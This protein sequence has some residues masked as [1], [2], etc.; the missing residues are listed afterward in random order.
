MLAEPHRAFDAFEQ[1]R[2]DARCGRA[3]RHR[4]GRY[5][6]SVTHCCSAGRC[7]GDT[8]EYGPRHQASATRIVE[9]E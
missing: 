9:I 6:V 2:E 7:T 4:A 8:S 3:E 1:F 5:T